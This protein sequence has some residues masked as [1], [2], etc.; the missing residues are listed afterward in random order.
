VFINVIFLDKYFFATLI[1]IKK[2]K[3]KSKYTFI[4]YFLKKK[5]L[6]KYFV[7]EFAN[8]DIKFSTKDV[9]QYRRTLIVLENNKI[10]IERTFY[11]LIL[12]DSELSSFC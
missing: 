5:S 12:R 10:D 2:K 3:K 4:Y 7:N 9:H 8:S 1:I 11:L 6:E